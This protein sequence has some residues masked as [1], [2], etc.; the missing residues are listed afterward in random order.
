MHTFL[1]LNKEAIIDAIETRGK[2]FLNNTSSYTM[3]D[4]AAG[5]KIG[6]SKK[7]LVSFSRLTR[8]EMVSDLALKGRTGMS[9]GR[10]ENASIEAS[11]LLQVVQ[12][13]SL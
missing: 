10:Y 1:K 8:E 2:Y 13:V 5:I 7:P 11:E 3:E 12:A 6:F 4:F 9:L